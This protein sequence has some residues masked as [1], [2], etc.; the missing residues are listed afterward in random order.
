[1]PVVVAVVSNWPPVLL[2]LPLG[3]RGWLMSAPL[4]YPV[5]PAHYAPL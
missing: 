1:M 5:T 4:S 2:G 3:L